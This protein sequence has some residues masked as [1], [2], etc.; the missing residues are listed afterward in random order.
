M[1]ADMG[2]EGSDGA[3]VTGLQLGEGAALA[4]VVRG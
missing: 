1:A 2:G 4:R 3:G